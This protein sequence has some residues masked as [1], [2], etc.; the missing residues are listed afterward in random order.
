MRSTLR[1]EHTF[2]G[3]TRGVPVRQYVVGVPTEPMVDGDECVSPDNIARAER[4]LA[5]AAM[6]DGFFA[7]SVLLFAR[8]AMGM[9]HAEVAREVMETPFAVAA[10]E[11]GVLKLPPVVADD[12]VVLLEQSDR[13]G[14]TARRMRG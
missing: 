9:S 8:T 3:A 4:A 10:W 7:P 14:L 6:R 1:I 11:T 5:L 12:L 13:G 2:V